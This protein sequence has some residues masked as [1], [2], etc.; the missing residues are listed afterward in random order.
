MEVEIS[1]E[2]YNNLRQDRR[3]NA[4]KPSAALDPFIPTRLTTSSANHRPANF[5]KSFFFFFFFETLDG[6]CEKWCN[7]MLN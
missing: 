7:L 2:I 4:D 3:W 5:L 6:N 1:A